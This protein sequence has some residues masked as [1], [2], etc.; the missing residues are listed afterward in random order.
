ME[1]VE[2][3]ISSS[4]S[5]SDD[6]EPTALRVPDGDHIF[7]GG[8]ARTGMSTTLELCG[9]GLG[10]TVEPDAASC[11]G[12]ADRRSSS[13]AGSTWRTSGPATLLVVDDADRVHDVDGLFAEI[14]R[15]DHPNVTIAAAAPG[16]RGPGRVRALD[17]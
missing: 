2:C 17:A 9:G 10:R 15:G 4:P 8:G 1:V 7:I 5:D 11:T 12:G 14:I 3:V 13:A 16:R 6:L